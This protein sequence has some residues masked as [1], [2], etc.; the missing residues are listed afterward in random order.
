MPQS[1]E[2]AVQVPLEEPA[3][4]VAKASKAARVASAEPE[5]SAVSVKPAGPEA[6]AE[7]EATAARALLVARAEAEAQVELVARE[8]PAMWE[9]PGLQVKRE[10][11]G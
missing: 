7:P 6:S 9:A 1:A 11:L 3:R 8:R 10:L 5:A 4:S 2:T